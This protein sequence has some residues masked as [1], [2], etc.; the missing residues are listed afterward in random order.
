MIDVDQI[1]THLP[2]SEDAF[3]SSTEEKAS[4]LQEALKGSS[5]STFAGNVVICHLYTQLL[6]H[7]HRP[8]PNDRPEDPDFGPFWKRHR[9][10]DNQLSSA[11]MFLPERFRLSKNTRD[12]IAVQANLNLHAAVICLHTAAREK[13]D[14]FKLGGLRQSSRTRALTA[15]QEIVDIV[16][17]SGQMA[18]GYKSPLVALSLYFASS[19][20]TAQAKESP[21]EFD[22]SNLELLIKCMNAIGRQHVIT[23]AYMNQLFRDME[24]NDISV[25]VGDL[26]AFDYLHHGS[27]H[28]IPLIARGFASRD[29]KVQPPL[30][31][32]LPLGAPVGTAARLSPFG[33]A[34]CA[35]FLGPHLD[36]SGGFAEPANKRMRTSTGASADARSSTASTSSWAAGRRGQTFVDPAPD[37]FEYTGGWSYSTKYTTTTA[38]TTLPHR[39]GSP[40]VD[41][42]GAPATAANNVTNFGCFS[43]PTSA[44]EGLAAPAFCGSMPDAG[45]PLSTGLG[46]AAGFG[47]NPAGAFNTSPNPNTNMNTSTGTNTGTDNLNPDD[48]ATDLATDLDVFENLGEWGVTDPESFYAMLLDVAGD[49]FGTSQPQEGGMDPWAQLNSAAGGNSGSGSGGGA[50]AGAGAGTWDTGGG[51]AGSG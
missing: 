49:D 36:V 29:T 16:K 24:R 50:G 43:I 11:F 47:L 46:A 17:G 37:L 14:K 44:A 48:L 35:T 28:S 31:G 15:A 25:S 6:K 41:N 3:R 51:A 18:T 4:T 33:F 19:V 13:A 12:P 34:P 10:L 20:Y 40:A 5:Y 39:M 38:T 8:M 32:R 27:G 1:T 22:K 2:V 30:P 23:H 42:R 9:E 21:E 45:L 7:A 26:T